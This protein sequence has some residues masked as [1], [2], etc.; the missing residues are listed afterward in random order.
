MSKIYCE[1]CDSVDCEF[2]ALRRRPSYK[3]KICYDFKY[4]GYCSKGMHCEYAHGDNQLRRQQICKYTWNY[5]FENI[6]VIVWGYGVDLRD[7]RDNVY[8][9]FNN[10]KFKNNT[11]RKLW[12]RIYGWI[13]HHNPIDVSPM[14]FSGYELY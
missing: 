7:A 4:N 2:L 10:F 5:E 13:I 6:G 1:Q 11:E 3:T 14:K 12:D 9:M 8:H